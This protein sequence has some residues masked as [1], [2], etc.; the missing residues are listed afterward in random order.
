MLWKF[1][2]K[3]CCENYEETVP[4]HKISTPGYY[5][6][7][8]SE[9]IGSWFDSNVKFISKFWQPLRKKCPH[10]ELLWSV[11]SRIR[12]EYGEIICIY[13]YSVRMRENKDRN[14]YEYGHFS[15]SVYWVLDNGKQKNNHTNIQ[16]SHIFIAPSPVC[17]VHCL[18][19]L[20]HEQD[21]DY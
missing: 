11:F 5:G 19:L 14:N 10:S 9:L 13:P 21:E 8:C 1:C 18:M 4:F 16:M 7:F 20:L 17:C 6:I 2:V 3:F 15:R 12:T